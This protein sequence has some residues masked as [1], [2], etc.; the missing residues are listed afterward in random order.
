MFLL[1]KS[2]EIGQVKR[3]K[4]FKMSNL[5]KEIEITVGAGKK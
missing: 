1:Q 2:I 3:I 5:N 4:V